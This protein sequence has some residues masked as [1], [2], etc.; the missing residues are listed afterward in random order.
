MGADWRSLWLDAPEKGNCA[1]EGIEYLPKTKKG[2]VVRT[3][4][5]GG[6]CEAA[7]T[8]GRRYLAD[9]K[10]AG[11]SRLNALVLYLRTRLRSASLNPHLLSS[12]CGNA[13]Q[14]IYQDSSP[15][16][17]RLP[18]TKVSPSKLSM[19]VYDHVKCAVT[20]YLWLAQPV[21]ASVEA[22]WCQQ[23]GIPRR[24][25]RVR[26]RCIALHFQGQR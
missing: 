10:C 7:G 4:A 18:N 14:R 6:F 19:S 20:C 26:L 5:F 12:P 11:N 21:V 3:A 9:W 25:S 1:S 22:R 16:R 24:S 8:D 15:Y 23:C 2:D 13:I 17:L